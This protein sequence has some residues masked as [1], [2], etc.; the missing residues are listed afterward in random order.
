MPRVSLVVAGALALAL[1]GCGIS[2][3]TA[4]EPVQPP[5]GAQLV[6]SQPPDIG[7]S[8]RTPEYLYFVKDGMVVRVARHVTGAPSTDEV[9]QDLLGG[10]ND[11]ESAAGYT[12]A[13][14]GDPI[15]ETVQVSSGRAAVALTAAMSEPGRNDVV[16]AY[17]QLVCT[18]TA[19]PQISGVVFTSNGTPIAVPRGDGSLSQGS[20][21]T[22]SDYTDLIGHP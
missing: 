6:Q 17:A 11:D 2:A 20:P 15:V 4:P 9:V 19:L 12:S 7:A 21:L 5:P 8:G 14:L 1:A 10:P 13:L 16:L 3:Q 18:L 22:A